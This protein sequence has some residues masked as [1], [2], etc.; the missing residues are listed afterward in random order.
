MLLETEEQLPRCLRKHVQFEK[1]VEYPN[2]KLPLK[3]RVLIFSQI[4]VLINDGNRTE[5]S[6][7]TK[8]GRTRSG[9]LICQP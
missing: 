1:F 7:L 5:Y 6:C 2:K 9:S 4:L 3:T 8:I